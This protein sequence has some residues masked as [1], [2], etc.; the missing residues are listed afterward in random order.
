M[1]RSGDP[2]FVELCLT[3]P[4]IFTLPRSYKLGTLRQRFAKTIFS[5]TKRCG[6]GTMLQL[7]ETMSQQCRNAVLR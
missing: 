7:F 6:V 5:A 4:I 3:N 1:W 2:T